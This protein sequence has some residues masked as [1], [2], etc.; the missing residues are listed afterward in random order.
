M[1]PE[2]AIGHLAQYGA[3][4]V[5][6]AAVLIVG[7]YVFKRMFDSMIDQNKMLLD[8]REKEHMDLKAGLAEI[9]ASVR[10]SKEETV[11]TLRD[12]RDDLV[13]VFQTSHHPVPQPVDRDRERSQV[14]PR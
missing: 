6:L 14:R 13:R 1:Q 5:I 12:M 11:A 8:R 4:G 2:T 3:V 10:D 9:S 7:L